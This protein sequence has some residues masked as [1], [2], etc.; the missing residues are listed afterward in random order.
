M[1]TLVL[2]GTGHLGAALVHEALARGFRVSVASR[3]QALPRSLAGLELEPLRVDIDD[4]AALRRA[5]EGHELV[6]DAAAPYPLHAR[7]QVHERAV[8]RM[9]SVIRAVADAGAKLAYVSSFVTLPGS[10]KLGSQWIRAAH[11]YFAVKQAMED[12][13]LRASAAGLRAVVVN[14]TACLGPWDDK[15]IEQ[16][17]I[18]LLL[19]QRLVATV[20]ATVN[21]I[22]VRDVA[23]G[24]LAAVERE[25]FGEPIA[26][27]GHNLGADQ[28]AARVCALAGVPA[29]VARVPLG[30]TV[31]GAIGVDAAY[32]MVGRESRYPGLSVL[33]IAVS[34][35]L[36]V[37]E[38]QREL[39]VLPRGL[40]ETLRDAIGWYRS[41]G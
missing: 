34:E 5:V 10:R 32:A 36:E 20:D 29:P 8:A 15:P 22:D 14:P 24:L 1:R 23:S 7:P 4:R 25:C 31:I 38:V 40:D 39:G 9:R 28:L 27:S 37:G 3:R 21:V 18:P 33:L 17:I 41:R 19:E 6:V 30:P 11:P 26:L 16:A 13:V 2:G 35:A 12:E